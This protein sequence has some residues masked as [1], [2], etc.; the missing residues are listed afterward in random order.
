MRSA[1]RCVAGAAALAATLAPATAQAGGGHEVLFRHQYASTAVNHHGSPDPLFSGTVVHV[2][3]RHRG[4]S[5]V[6]GWNAD[7]NSFG[8]RVKVT[9]ARLITRAIEASMVGCSRAAE[10]RDRWL[11]SFFAADPAWKT[12]RGGKLKLAAG[13]RSIELHSRGS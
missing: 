12:G 5:D 8:A 11:E 13:H 9:D 10:R 3:F 4:G 6:V 1:A 2:G 7:C